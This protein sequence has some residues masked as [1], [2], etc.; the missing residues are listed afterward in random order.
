MP[1]AGRPPPASVFTAPAVHAT[2]VALGM[3]PGERDDEVEAEL[4]G[5]VDCVRALAC[6]EALAVLLA[7]TD[8]DGE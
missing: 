8:T 7:E 1:S 3:A 6:G 4:L 5:E 2:A